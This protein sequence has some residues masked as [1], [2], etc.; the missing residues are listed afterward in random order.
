MTDND[1]EHSPNL[2]HC[3]LKAPGPVQ[4]HGL[5]NFKVGYIYADVGYRAYLL[6]VLVYV[7]GFIL[8]S[9]RAIAR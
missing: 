3:Q 8:L 7:V 4:D 2:K 9:H 5:L 1:L 6:A